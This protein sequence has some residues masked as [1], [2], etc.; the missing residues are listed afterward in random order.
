MAKKGKRS[1]ASYEMAAAA[2]PEGQRI[3]FDQLVRNA[4]TSK[5]F[6]A[7]QE[8]F[9]YEAEKAD[10]VSVLLSSAKITQ[11][12]KVPKEISKI[13]VDMTEKIYTNVEG[14]GDHDETTVKIARTV[15]SSE[16]YSYQQ[17]TTNGLEWG[18]GANVGVQ[19]GLPQV[20]VG[21]SVGGDGRVK[22]TRSTAVT[23]EKTKTST[24]GQESHHEETMKIPSGKRVLVKMTLY[25]VRYELEYKMLYIVPK[26]LKMKVWYRCCCGL[27]SRS[28]YLTA[29][30]LLKSLPAYRVE[31]KFVYFEQEGKLYWFA[32]RMVVDKNMSPAGN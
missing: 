12:S 11:Q 32:D 25:R 2:S 18:V 7:V 31:G 26:Q 21:A 3:S 20:G 16:G 28:C 9:L 17:T 10:F 24:I 23:E 27:C 1:S 4:L 30:E 14:S 19:F 13:Q 5:H 22:K 6:G 8:N 29:T 15:Q